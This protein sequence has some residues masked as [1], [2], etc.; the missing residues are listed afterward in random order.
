MKKTIY[1]FKSFD[2]DSREYTNRLKGVTQY[3]KEVAKK[4]GCPINKELSHNTYGGDYYVNG[5]LS[6]IDVTE[7]F[8]TI[9]VENLPDGIEAIIRNLILD[10]DVDCAIN[11]KLI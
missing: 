10:S 8:E 3:I 2:A 7:Y 6:A 9:S 5:G 11:G 4:C 1:C